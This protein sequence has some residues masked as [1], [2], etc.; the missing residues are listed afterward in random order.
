MHGFNLCCGTASEGLVDPGRELYDIVRYFGER[1]KIFNIHFRN[2]VG[3]LH[4][5]AEVRPPCERAGAPVA[6]RAIA[7]PRGPCARDSMR[8]PVGGASSP[9]R[10]EGA[11][12]S[13]R[14]ERG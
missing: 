4:D 1:K 2:I 8:P 9:R 10:C 3:G 6:P 13:C 7:P 14:T 11:R 12:V 5:F